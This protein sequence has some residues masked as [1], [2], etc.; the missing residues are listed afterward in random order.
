ML[1]FDTVVAYQWDGDTAMTPPTRRILDD[2]KR[3]EGV[4]A[5]SDVRVFAST[6]NRSQGT[7]H[8]G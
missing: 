2:G 5:A 8:A 6:G 1:T 7:R 3:H 4:V